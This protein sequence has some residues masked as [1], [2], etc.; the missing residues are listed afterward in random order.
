M[1]FFE[2]VWSTI[3]RANIKLVAYVAAAVCWPRVNP[4][5]TLVTF[6]R[7]PARSTA[8]K[9][10]KDGAGTPHRRGSLAGFSIFVRRVQTS[11]IMGKECKPLAMRSESIRRVLDTGPLVRMD[12]R[13]VRRVRCWCAVVDVHAM[14][15]DHYL[16][17]IHRREPAVSNSSNQLS[18]YT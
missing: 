4:A 9:S 6:A 1:C 18:L 8:L 12:L 10:E 14:E 7:R 16:G 2:A 15:G 13:G 17:T 5:E 11:N 3:F